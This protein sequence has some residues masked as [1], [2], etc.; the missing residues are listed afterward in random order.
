MAQEHSGTKCTLSQQLVLLFRAG[1]NKVGDA[2]AMLCYDC[3]VGVQG[4]DKLDAGG[5][6]RLDCRPRARVKLC[7]LLV[8]AHHVPAVGVSVLL[9]H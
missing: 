1:V 7:R 6:A 3:A 8:V 9:V 2:R 4:L 5:G